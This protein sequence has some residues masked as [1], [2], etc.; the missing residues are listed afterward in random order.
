MR[1]QWARRNPGP[2]ELRKASGE[3]GKLLLCLR[4]GPVYKME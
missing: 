2:E 3:I 4:L 1:V